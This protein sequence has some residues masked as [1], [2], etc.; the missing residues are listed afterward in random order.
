M[1]EQAVIEIL[2]GSIS[3]I[4][5]CRA[6]KSFNSRRLLGCYTPHQTILCQSCAE[7]VLL[8]K[9]HIVSAKSANNPATVILSSV[10]YRR[11]YD[12]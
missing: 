12:I 10:G 6:S 1:L 7:D 4:K 5:P 11:L 3:L 9:P 8:P 2:I